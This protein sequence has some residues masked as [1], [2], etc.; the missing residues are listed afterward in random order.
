MKAYATVMISL[1]LVFV[2]ASATQASTTIT[3][4]T[5]KSID[6]GAQRLTVDTLDG[7]TYSLHVAHT[8]QIA[9]VTVGDRVT[10]E[11]DAQERIVKIVKISSGLEVSPPPSS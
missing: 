4:C 7:Q 2:L 11:L 6:Q 9:G 5:I 1:M 3:G 8:E 10:I